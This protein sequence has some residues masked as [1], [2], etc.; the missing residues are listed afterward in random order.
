MDTIIYL[1]S[2]DLNGDHKGTMMGTYINDYLQVSYKGNNIPNLKI[3]KDNDSKFIIEFRVNRKRYRK[4][5]T[6]DGT[7]KGRNIELARR[8]L[9]QY[10][11]EI[12]QASNKPSE[13]H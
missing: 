8:V 1:N 13:E 10:I 3:H 2:G 4:T 5:F 9:D 7:T 12:S 6:V 11:T